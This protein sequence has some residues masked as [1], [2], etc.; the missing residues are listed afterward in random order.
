M[1][2]DHQCP[3]CGQRLPLGAWLRTQTRTLWTTAELVGRYGSSEEYIGKEMARLGFTK[4]SMRHR[5]P[6]GNLSKKRALY[7]VKPE[8]FAQFKKPWPNSR[9]FYDLRFISLPVTCL[10]DND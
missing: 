2:S 7:C 1:K 5:L 9:C 3:H 6:G 10:T 8:S 4:R